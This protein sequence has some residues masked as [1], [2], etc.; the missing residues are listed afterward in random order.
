M[1]GLG[2]QELILILIIVLVLFGGNKLPEL[3][4]SLG[5]GVR[6][7]KNETEQ[8]QEAYKDTTTLDKDAGDEEDKKPESESSQQKNEAESSEDEEEEA[9]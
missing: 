2:P 5:K 4:R 9:A 1:F 8:I 3:A 6:E 7:F